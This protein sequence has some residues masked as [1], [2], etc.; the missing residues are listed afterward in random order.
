[1][2]I[3]GTF[4]GGSEDFVEMTAEVTVSALDSGAGVG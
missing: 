1:M 3:S 4:G 2:P